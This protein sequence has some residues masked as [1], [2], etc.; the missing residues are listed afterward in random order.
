[1]AKLDRVQ[2]QALRRA[3]GAAKSTPVVAM[4][5]QTYTPP[6]TAR[7]NKAA[8]CLHEKLLRLEEEEWDREPLERLKT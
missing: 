8:I 5:M 7:R 2:N 1:M 3:T 4:E 6:L